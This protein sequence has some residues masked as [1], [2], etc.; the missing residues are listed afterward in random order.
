MSQNHAA[1]QMHESAEVG[2][3]RRRP[4]EPPVDRDDRSPSGGSMMLRGGGRRA[5]NT[6]GSA[7][8]S[9]RSASRSSQQPPGPAAPRQARTASTK[10]EPHVSSLAGP[11]VVSQKPPSARSPAG[12]RCERG[13]SGAAG[14][15]VHVARLAR[16]ARRPARNLRDPTAAGGAT[17]SIQTCARV[18]LEDAEGPR[19]PHRGR[20]P[21]ATSDRRT[22][23]RAA[24]STSSRELAL[25]SGGRT[26]TLSTS[27]SE[28]TTPLL[29]TRTTTKPAP[30]PG[31]RRRRRRRDPGHRPTQ[32]HHLRVP[33]R[34]R[35]R[36]VRRPRDHHRRRT[37]S[38]STHH[39]LFIV[40]NST[41]T[42]RSR[43]PAVCA[44]DT[45]CSTTGPATPG[46]VAAM[47]I[48]TTTDAQRQARTFFAELERKLTHAIVSLEG[49]VDHA[50]VVADD[51]RQRDAPP[52][53]GGRRR[54]RPRAEAPARAC[55]R[56]SSPAL[57]QG[58][59]ARADG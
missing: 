28:T 12:S 47:A 58:G 23:P 17:C 54:V 45:V 40:G 8:A 34:T 53:R 35:R 32:D 59:T 24:S 4:A 48:G 15:V 37:R 1:P 43:V 36:A 29:W 27:D 22:P 50:D 30:W 9:A 26:S 55:Q 56:L 46:T 6:R 31:R 51:E 14:R 57:R 16:R 41:P 20:Q 13:R 38:P 2:A 33:G 52:W 39:F 25:R 49:Q 5:P 7:S 18:A 3:E 42:E 10:A 21:G 19:R 44:V 11:C